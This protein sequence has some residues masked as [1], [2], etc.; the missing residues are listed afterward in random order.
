MRQQMRF[1]ADENRMLLFA[2]I[3]AH[4]GVGNLA[5]Q[6]ATEV[7]RLEVQRQCDLAQQIERRAGSEVDIE[8]L[9][10]NPLDHP[11]FAA[12]RSALA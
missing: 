11:H 3:Q 5:H 2:L 7:R 9:L 1:V 8:D 12:P 6:V 10:S 4:D